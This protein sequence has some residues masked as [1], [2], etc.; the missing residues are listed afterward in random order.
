MYELAVIADRKGQTRRDAQRWLEKARDAGTGRDDRA[1]TSHSSSFIC[2][3]G[4]RPRRSTQPRLASG[5]GAGGPERALL[6]YSRAQLAIGDTVGAKSTLTSATRF[7]EYN[8]PLQVQIATLQLSANNLAGA[9]YSLDKALSSRPDFLPAQALMTEVELRQGER[10]KAEKR[11][12][13]ILAAESQAGRRATPCWAT[14]PWPGARPARRSTPID[15]HTR[16]MLPGTGSL[17]SCSARCPSR[18][19]SKPALQLAEQWLKTHPRDLTVHKALA[20][21]QARAGNFTAARTAYETAL[22]LEP[23]RRGSY[24]TTWPMCSCA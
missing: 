18:D 11:A 15:A 21:G 24:S 22:K 13:D 10:A 19:D 7:A 5:Q 6:T 17:L 2:V 8:A 23:E 3:T 20:D 16:S 14:S 4:A 9:A 1:G 12:R